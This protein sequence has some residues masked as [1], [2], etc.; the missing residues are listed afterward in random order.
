MHPFHPSVLGALGTQHGVASAKQL[1]ELGLSRRQVTR[2]VTSGQLTVV[3]RSV[4]RLAYFPVTFES[5][6]AAASLADDGVA[7]SHQSAARLAG[8]RQMTTARLHVT[9][10]CRRRPIGPGEIVVHRTRMFLPDHMIER[11]DKIRVTT[12]ARTLFDLASAVGADRLETAVE[13]ALQLR[14]VEYSH[15][16]NMA[17][18]MGKRGRPGSR[19]FAALLESRPAT[20]TAVDSNDELVLER[21]LIAAG[22]PAPVR[23]YELRLPDAVPIHP[24]L[25]WPDIRLA[26]EVDHRTWHETSEATA[27]DNARDRQVRM[28][29][30]Q[31]ERVSDREIERNLPAVV[32]DLSKLYALR[33]TTHDR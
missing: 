9:A 22:L 21:A 31:V 29:S 19:R 6:C 15:L 13:H 1:E 27:A 11:A 8:I 20:Q 14:I 28:V 4:F 30:W 16:T 18:Q 2:M 32:R 23:Q 3:H 17:E 10:P 5:V 25:A 24:D 26:V 7:V 12:V 33:V